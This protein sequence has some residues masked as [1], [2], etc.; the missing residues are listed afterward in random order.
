MSEYHAR[1][2][3]KVDGKPHLLDRKCTVAVWAPIGS[4]LTCGDANDIGA[5][6][7]C[8]TE[9]SCTASW[10]TTAMRSHK[11]YRRLGQVKAT[12]K[13]GCWANR[14]AL[15]C[16]TNMKECENAGCLD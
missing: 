11:A 9:G 6:V 7:S 10:G 1:C 8:E 4:T 12:G 2:T 3:V 14:Q 13:T 16:F 5:C 15:I